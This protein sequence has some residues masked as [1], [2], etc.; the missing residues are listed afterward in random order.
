[1]DRRDIRRRRRLFIP[2]HRIHLLR[3]P[4]LPSRVE[5]YDLGC[6]E[7][8]GRCS[9]AKYIIDRVVRYRESP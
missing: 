8:G 3:K 7:N 9:R 2:R 6:F 4:L 1:M 5:S